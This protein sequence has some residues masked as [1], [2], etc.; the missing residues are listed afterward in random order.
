[1]SAASIIAVP[2]VIGYLTVQAVSAPSGL[3]AFFAP[4]LTCALCIGAS[5]VLGLE[6]AICV[7][8]ASPLMLLG[9]SAGG[10]LGR[11]RQLRSAAGRLGLLILPPGLAGIELALPLQ[12]AGR[13]AGKT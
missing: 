2:I 13:I 5:F 8:F 3:Y 6:G 9:S 11:T 1:M 12:I 10:Q 4:W 7:V